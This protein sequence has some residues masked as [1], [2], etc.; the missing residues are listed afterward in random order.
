[1]KDSRHP[2]KSLR[3]PNRHARKRLNFFPS[4]KGLSIHA[5]D[6]YYK[7]RIWVR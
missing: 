5:T 7:G 2:T 1:M 3:K 6:A 4:E